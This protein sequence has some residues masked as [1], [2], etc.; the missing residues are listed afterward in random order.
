MVAYDSNVIQEMA[1]KLY[2]QARMVEFVWA[3]MGIFIGGGMAG[4]ALFAVSEG[5]GL[6][7]F[8][9][10]ALFGAILGFIIGRSRAFALRLAAQT[11]LCQMRIEQNTAALLSR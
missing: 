11:A 5:L 7:G 2:S 6:M 4:G 1:D 10:G 8:L 9:G 3:V